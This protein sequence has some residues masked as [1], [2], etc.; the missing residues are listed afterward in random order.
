[1]K[2]KQL[3][4][5]WLKEIVSR[6]FKP[7]KIHA[8]F[9]DAMFA[10]VSPQSDQISTF[11]RKLIFSL[12]GLPGS[13]KTTSL[14]S[15][16][17][18]HNVELID[19]ILPCE[20]LDSQPVEFYLNSEEKKTKRVTT[21]KHKIC[22]L[23]RYYVSTLAFYWAT[24]KIN[25]TQR[26]PQVYDWYRKSMGNGKIIKPFCVFYI[27]T[28]IEMSYFRKNRK[29]DLNSENPWLNPNFLAYFEEYCH[30]FYATTEPLTRICK[31]D[32]R[33]TQAEILGEIKVIIKE[34]E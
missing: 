28:P 20:P 9:S 13:G 23:D 31:L 24:D 34:Y 14:N 25:N 16:K 11:P 12:E 4:P 29:P 19:Q 30:N 21:S 2:N 6:G 33:K 15:F 1:M 22:L 18:S 7:E 8:Y 26:Y 17:T 27:E 5:Q 3:L 10:I 32:G